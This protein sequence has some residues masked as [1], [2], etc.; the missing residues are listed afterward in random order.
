MPNN[1][2]S[3]AADAKHQKNHGHK[4]GT[5]LK[6]PALIRMP[7]HA[8][9]LFGQHEELVDPVRS[10]QKPMSTRSLRERL[11]TCCPS[12]GK[13]REAEEFC[14]RAFLADRTVDQ[15]VAAILDTGASRTVIGK[16]QYKRFLDQLPTQVRSQI[17]TAPSQVIFR[18]GNNGTLP[19]LHSTYIPYGRKWFKVEVVDGK[20]PFLLSNAV[21]RQLRCKLD[22]EANNLWIP[23]SQQTIPLKVGSKGLYYID[24]VDFLG[25]NGSTEPIMLEYDLDREF[26]AGI[27]DHPCTSAPPLTSSIAAPLKNGRSDELPR[28]S[29]QHDRGRRP[30]HRLCDSSSDHSAHRSDKS[31]AMGNLPARRGQVQG[32]LVHGS[33]QQSSRVYPLYTRKKIDLSIAEKLS[34]LCSRYE[35]RQGAR[36]PGRSSACRRISECP[37]GTHGRAHEC[38]SDNSGLQELRRDGIAASDQAQPEDNDFQRGKFNGEQLHRAGRQAPLGVECDRR[39]GTGPASSEGSGPRESAGAPNPDCHFAEGAGRSSESQSEVKTTECT[40]ISEP[41]DGVS[42]GTPKV[43]DNEIAPV[44]SPKELGIEHVT[45]EVQTEQGSPGV[46]SESG[47]GASVLTPEQ[48]ALLNTELERAC[49]L[50]EQQVLIAQSNA[51]ALYNPR[52]PKGQGTINL[53]EISIGVQGHVGRFLGGVHGKWHRVDFARKDLTG[54]SFRN[55]IWKMMTAISPRHLWLSVGLQT[56]SAAEQHVL[57]E[58]CNELYFEQV[59]SGNHF[60][61]WCSPVCSDLLDGESD[62]LT[63]T[64]PTYYHL[65]HVPRIHRLQGNNHLRQNMNFRTTSL[66]IHQGMDYRYLEFYKDNLPKTSGYGLGLARCLA[67]LI[68]TC[69]D[70]RPLAVEELCT[71]VDGKRDMSQLSETCGQVL[72]RRKCIN[73]QAP[74]HHNGYGKAT[75]DWQHVFKSLNKRA[76]RVG[77]CIIPP[78]DEII[79]NIQQLIPEMK[80]HHVEACRGTNR[81]RIPLGQ[82]DV[83]LIRCRKTIVIHR[84][85]GNIEDCGPVEDWSVLPKYKQIRQ[86]KPAKMAITVFGTTDNPLPSSTPNQETGRTETRETANAEEVPMDTVTEPNPA[87]ASTA[88]K[89]QAWGP[90]PVANHGPGFLNLNSREQSEIR[91]LHHNLGHPSPQKFSQYL[92]QGGACAAVQK[93]ALDYQCDAC[94]ESRKGFMAARPSAIHENISFNTK[95]GMDLVSWRNSKGKEFH[96]VHFIDEAT[97][98]HLG[99]EC[100]QG[101]TGVIGMF[102]QVWVTWAGQ[103]QEVYVDPGGEFVSDAWAAQMQAAGIHVHMSASD[104][105]WQLGRAE[106]HGSTVKQMLS[107]MDLEQSIESSSEF[108]RA[109]RQAFNAKNS[110]CRADGYSP[111]QAVLGVSCRLPGSILSDHNAASHVLADSGTEEGGRVPEGQ[112]FLQELQLRERARRAFITVDNSSSFRRALLR[113]TRPVRNQWEVGDLVLYWRRR[114]SNMRREHGRWHGPAE[115][116]ALEKSKVVWLSHSGRL[117]RASPEQ[118]RAASLREWQNIPKDDKGHPL[119]QL[120]NLKDHLKSAPQYVDLEGEET[121]PAEALEQPVVE[122]LEGSEPDAEM[123][124][125]SPSSPELPVSEQRSEPSN[126]HVPSRPECPRPL[127]DSEL[128]EQAQSREVPL[129]D[130]A[131]SEQLD[132]QL[133]FGDEVEVDDALV[134]DSDICWEID[135]TPPEGWQLPAQLD[136]DMIFLASEGRKKRTEVRLRDLTVQDQKRFAAAK[137]KEVHA[138]LSHRTV[139]RVA[140]G[141]IPEKN[142]MR[143][144]W[145]YTWKAADASNAE[146]ADGRKAKARL[147]VLGFEDPDIDHVANDAP[148]LSKDGRQLLLQKICSNRWKL[149]S[150]DISTAFLHGKG[151]GRLLGIQAPPEL[152]EALSMGPQD[153]CELVGGAYG[154]VDAPYLWYQELRK[155]LLTLGFQQCPLDPCLFSLTE[156]D[157]KGRLRCHGVLGIHVDDGICGGDR[158]FHEVLEQ[159]RA[160]FSFGSFEEGSFTFTGIRLHQWDDSSIEMDQRDYVEGIE[161]IN[162]SRERRKNPESPLTETERARFRQL[163]GSLQYA[164]VHTRA[165]IS[166]KVGELQSAVNRAQ[167]THLLEANRVLYEAKTNPVSIMIVPIAEN[168]VTFCAFSDASFASS[169]KLS[170]HQ[171]SMIFATHSSILE[172]QTAVVCPMAWSSKRIPRVV[173]STLG[174]EAFA[175]SNSVDRLSWIRIL[176]AWLKDAEVKW[177]EPENLLQKE[178]TAAAVTDCKSVYDLITRTAPPQCE[179]FRTTIECFLIRQRMLEN[180][181]LRWVASG[182][183]LADCLTKPMD[184]ARLPECLRTGR[185]SLFDEGMIL[186]QRSDKRKQLKWVKGDKSDAVTSEQ[187]FQS[188]SV[189]FD[190]WKLDRVKGYLDRV[191]VQPRKVRFTPIG[192]SECPV[193]F[194]GIGVKR[195]THKTE[196]SPLKFSVIAD[197]WVGQGAYQDEGHEWTGFTRFYLEPKAHFSGSHQQQSDSQNS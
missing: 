70:E 174:A 105:H 92:K 118:I 16:V 176:W 74:S 99:A 162:V 153:Q 71:H 146:T 28:P 196:S 154:R 8:L 143:C 93:G 157:S 109:L 35:G 169:T 83:H 163:I 37:L 193:G 187:C 79:Q 73:K 56:L 172:N 45:F 65:G 96:F 177:Q 152:Q 3:T 180:C 130:D 103:P 186:K 61:L 72:K 57:R 113:R 156:R 21:L 123:I 189:Q 111:Q 26:P 184:A 124:P 197:H 60:H 66:K 107:R 159:L 90:P 194:G 125:E 168:E 97:L 62:V 166:A 173:R 95:V 144:R 50:C 94:V 178:P 195:T 158:R 160:L 179:E 29:P 1:S 81:L 129:H 104:S 38:S 114:G 75:A 36:T 40:V 106:I 34:G 161:P 12:W 7:S 108:Q 151:D 48:L 27:R 30:E 13:L 139:K 148:T 87:P 68:R 117:I 138:W 80:V 5:P 132:E 175:L 32:S 91:Q 164:A 85:S 98:F 170:A 121:P 11:M 20:T 42:V 190:Y 188:S 54:A 115:I 133:E 89:D 155:S 136:E 167:V 165:D 53:L 192:V 2:A 183:M 142:I 10:A 191:H 24:M 134:C 141:K 23:E 39:S 58:L 67:M 43:N 44:G 22:F 49:L 127:T 122:G 84:N 120:D 47:H 116:I 33:S 100:L 25:L 182:A 101:A 19:S 14:D 18:F 15:A 4:K 102:E 110:L 59:S 137:N 6:V 77:N 112:R 76:P 41:C 51:R 126:A 150:F 86:G 52:Q 17:K 63:G 88:N 147:V 55:T 149:C 128:S 9:T 46:G 31:S 185:Y 131:A 145:I 171:G 119:V 82:Y 181:R 69:G 78:D 135:I 64:L 140:K